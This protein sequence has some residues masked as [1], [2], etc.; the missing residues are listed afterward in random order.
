MVPDQQ[1]SATPW[2]PRSIESPLVY[3]LQVSFESVNRSS[4]TDLVGLAAS[5]TNAT[6]LTYAHKNLWLPLYKFQGGEKRH[7]G[8]RKTPGGVFC[9]LAKKREDVDL[10]KV[11]EVLAEHTPRWQNKKSQ[12][13]TEAA[14]AATLSVQLDEFKRKVE[15]EK[16]QNSSTEK[17]TTEKPLFEAMIWLCV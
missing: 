4:K 13:K 15:E 6:N 7:N 2:S 17:S 11:E 9:S 16:I 12:N 5:H 3:T 14:A 8:G 10:Q 1:G